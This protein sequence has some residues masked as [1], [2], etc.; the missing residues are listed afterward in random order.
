MFTLLLR[1]VQNACAKGSTFETGN[2]YALKIFAG[3]KIE[4][5]NSI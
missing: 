3:A 2:S 4:S 1:N 5:N